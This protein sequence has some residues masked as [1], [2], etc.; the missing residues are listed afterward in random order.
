M[1]RIL[2]AFILA[3]SIIPM[4]SAGVSVYSWSD[5]AGSAVPYPTDRAP[6][7][8]PDSLTPVMIMH[9]GRHGAR[10]PTTGSCVEEVHSFLM[11]AYDAGQ[12]TEAG[13]RLLLIADSINAVGNG[14]WGRLD[15][16]GEAEQRGIAARMYVSAPNLFDKG[17]RIESLASWKPR[18]VMSMYSFI[19]QLTL[20]NKDGLDVSSVSGSPRCDTL[21]RF[22]DTDKAY[23]RLIMSDTLMKIAT[24]YEEKVVDDR[25]ATAILR[26]LAG[27]SLPDGVKERRWTAMAVYSMIGSCAAMDIRIDPSE[28]MTRDE[29]ERCWSCKNLSQYL[30]YSASDISNIPAEMAAP[31]LRDMIDGIE[32]FLEG[33]GSAPVKLRFG[34]AE[35]LMPLMSLMKIPAA[36]YFTRD[37]DMVKSHWRNFDI[38]PMAA[39]VTITVFRSRSGRD[40]ARLDVNEVTIPLIPGSD[41]EY[42]EW[43]EAREYLES[44]LPVSGGAD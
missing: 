21:L 44:C 25:V 27:K 14:K 12:L 2:S 37:L 31:L 18:C 30:R 7:A 17:A 42:I 24:S 9:V 36:F 29:Y 3:L 39:N 6:I 34:H 8:H 41:E 4:I 40:Y 43:D 23:R 20:L 13:K 22:F 38:V 16:L 32:S 33:D 35:T 1:K 15:P 11:K 26:R 19:H 10:Y 5:L 28:W